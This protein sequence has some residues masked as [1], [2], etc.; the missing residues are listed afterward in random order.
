MPAGE[1]GSQIIRPNGQRIADHRRIHRRNGV[2]HRVI[3]GA[4]LDL[5]VLNPRQ[6]RS[7]QSVAR[8]ACRAD[9]L[10]ST[11]ATVCPAKFFV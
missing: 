8:A 2:N 10:S 3:A 1:A 5:H 4:G 7:C 11:P 9:K 6:S